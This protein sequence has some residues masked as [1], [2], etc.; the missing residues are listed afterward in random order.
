MV[1]SHRFF[2]KRGPLDE[3]DARHRQGSGERPALREKNE[4]DREGGTKKGGDY[5]PPFCT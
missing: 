2:V 1:S 5:S 4:T 3:S